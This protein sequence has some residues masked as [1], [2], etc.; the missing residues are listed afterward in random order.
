MTVSAPTPPATGP[1]GMKPLA[2][3]RAPEGSRFPDGPVGRGLTRPRRYTP[4]G[5]PAY[6]RHSSA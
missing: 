6:V 5:S 1:L 4:T 3:E 2:F